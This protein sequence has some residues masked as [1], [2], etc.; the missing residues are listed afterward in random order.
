M[1]Q[2]QHEKTQVTLVSVGAALALTTVK[3][4]VGLLTGSLGM[5]S[6][7]AHSG[8][9]LVA[10]VITFISVR[11]AERPADADHPYGHGRVE[12][13]SATLQGLLLL[14]TAGWI[15]YES[16]IRIF[17]HSVRV[18]ASVWTVVVMGAS[19]G[20]DFWRS[21]MLL[22]AARKFHSAALEADALNFRADMYSSAVVIVGL[23]LTYAGQHLGGG[24]AW[25]E[26]ADAVAAL[27]VAFMIMRMSGGLAG[28]AIGVLLDRAPPNLAERM[29]R[30][31]LAVPG[32]VQ[33]D[34]V[35][36]RESGNRLFADVVVTAPRT[37][38]LVEA[39]DLSDRVEAAVRSVEP[40][41]ETLVHVEPIRTETETAA[42][43]IRAVSLRL[44]INT[45]HEQVFRADGR[46]EASLHVEVDP[47]LPLREAHTIA[48]R[49]V[50]AVRQDNPSLT[51]VDTHIEVAAPAPVPRHR[52]E[53]GTEHRA[54]QI[55]RLVREL[56]VGAHCHEARLYRTGATGWGAV[57]HCAFDPELPM[58]EIHRR[59]EQIEYALRQ[60]FPDLVYALIQAEPAASGGT[61]PSLVARRA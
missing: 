33:A 31:I 9:D 54:E 15:V 57:L 40:R 55:L 43:R 18:G 30:A 17:V 10:S 34:R 42:E 47:E 60:H 50:A 46:L 29:T 59:T 38:S 61:P 5:L 49:L 22:A 14:A 27:V 52:I 39:H 7:A 16:V 23:A 26:K 2:E 24:A 37:A 41:T 21:R 25:L 53:S 36:L 12:N 6:E 28:R 44:G 4:I 45:H 35:R 58:R 1:A 13:V 20:I 48:D 32:V 8:L 19:I 3:L 51:K 56:G 11:I